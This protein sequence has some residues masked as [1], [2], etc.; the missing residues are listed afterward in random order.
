MF[1]VNIQ[2]FRS[3]AIGSMSVVAAAVLAAITLLPAVLSVTGRWIDRLHLP[4]T[5][6][7]PAVDGEGFWHRWA[8]AV[9]RRPWTM[10]GVSLAIL[11][12]LAIP[13]ASLRMGQPGPSV[14]PKDEQPRVAAELLAREF[15]AGVTGP[16]EILVDTPGGLGNVANLQRIEA[17]TRTLRSDPAV[18]SV[19]SPTSVVP[20]LTAPDAY[21]QL[22]A[23]GLAGLDPRLQPVVAGMA[24]WSHG[25]TEARITAVTK[26]AP[27]SKQAEALID[28]IRD[29]YVPA[30]GFTAATA[31]VGGSTAFNLD[32]ERAIS[33]RLPVV[34]LA[35]LALSFLLLMM[36]FRSLLLPL[37]AIVMNLLSVGA[38][39]GF[40]VALFQW[41]WGER[42]LGFTSNGHIEVFVPMFLFSILFGLSMDYEVF[43]MSRMREEY[44]RTGSNELA[45]AHGL[46][47]T[48]RTITSAAIVMVTVFVAFAASRVVPFKEMGVG[49]A[50][51]VFIDATVVR[52]V[53]VPAAMKLM[54]DWNW[55]MPAWLDRWLPRISLEAS[56]ESDPAG[57]VEG[58]DD[59]G[60]ER[61]LTA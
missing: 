56:G 12:T 16:V 36:A 23:N 10:V 1:L 7:H 27:E 34:V 61:V 42:L 33:H 30:A 38:A 9:M 15:G 37:K 31:R 14:L 52:T 48:A 6:R 5:G 47:G 46:E 45:V 13:F 57:A 2:A 32:L 28:R 41:G 60:R 40:I 26:V 29:R 20:T 3:M 19:V 25:A 18:A 59:L 49:L 51:A 44:H 8:L 21:A 22:Y 53:L 24:D 43:L 11:L 58:E 50:V 4:F 17:L 55:W 39:Y 35:V 54:G